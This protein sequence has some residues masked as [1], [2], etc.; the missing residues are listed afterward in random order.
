[1]TLREGRCAGIGVRRRYG[2]GAH[3]DGQGQGKE[4][5][6]SCRRVEEGSRV[7]GSTKAGQVFGR[8]LPLGPT[9]NCIE[10]GRSIIHVRR[11]CNP[12]GDHAYLL[13]RSQ[14]RLIYCSR[15]AHHAVGDHPHVHRCGYRALLA[16]NFAVSI[17]A[18]VT[19]MLVM[20]QLQ[21]APRRSPQP[22][23]KSARV[24]QLLPPCLMFHP[25][26]GH[27]R[28]KVAPH[29]FVPARNLRSP[30]HSPAHTSPRGIRLS[31][32]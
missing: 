11:P 18:S 30:V 2:L 10:G 8:P 26:V 7:V 13:L 27:R 22:P 5:A 4:K 23:A 24:N 19:C 3:G 12:S 21:A 20:I 6:A 16:V 17:D 9:M 15:S 31:H 14:M 25:R 32:A 28:R 29:D 1:M